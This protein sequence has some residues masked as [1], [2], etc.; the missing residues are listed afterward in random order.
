MTFLSTK[1]SINTEN[2]ITMNTI[3]IYLIYLVIAALITLA[4]GN[5]LHSNGYYLILDLFKN[6][7]FTETVNNL[8]LTGYYLVNIGYIATTVSQFGA[9][10]TLSLAVEELSYKIGIIAIILGVLHFNN[11]IILHFLSKRKQL[12]LNL[13]NT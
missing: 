10:D 13:I 7:E 12:I 2:K 8:L 3:F 1:V 9:V 6:Q 11:I 5:N 4:V